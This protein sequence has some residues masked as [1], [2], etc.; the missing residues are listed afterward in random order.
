MKTLAQKYA[1]SLY[2][3]TRDLEKRKAADAV[4][5]F[6]ELLAKRGRLRL[7]PAILAAFE[8]RANVEE[9]VLTVRLTT[10]SAPAGRTAKELGE[11]LEKRL[12]R[13]TVLESGVDPGILGGAIIRFEDTLLDASLK[14]R[15][16]RLKRH[17]AE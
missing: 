17:I 16:E 6:V 14:R 12:G 8:R 4:R 1:D 13:K 2:E 3:L 7:G 5:R 9:G 15:L 10:A 11:Q